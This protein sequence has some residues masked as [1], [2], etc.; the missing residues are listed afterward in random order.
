MAGPLFQGE[1]HARGW[2]RPRLWAEGLCGGTGS[3]LQHLPVREQAQTRE[4]CGGS[5]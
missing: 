4:T 3:H 2:A 5:G 1:T